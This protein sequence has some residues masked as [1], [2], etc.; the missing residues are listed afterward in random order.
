MQSTEGA[1]QGRPK[2]RIFALYIFCFM[3][4]RHDNLVPVGRQD[5]NLEHGPQQVLMLKMPVEPR[6]ILVVPCGAGMRESA[7]RRVQVW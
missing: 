1:R 5:S 7:G 2:C 4:S 6:P 3:Y